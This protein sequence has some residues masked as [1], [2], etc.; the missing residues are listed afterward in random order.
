M[1]EEE[2]FT[3]PAVRTLLQR[4]VCVRLDVDRRPPEAVRYGV[5]SI[6]RLLVLPAGSD[7]PVMD[8]QGFLDAKQLA[9]ELRR[10]LGLKLEQA[11]PV[12]NAELTLV[13]RALR[14]R[15]F[16][17]LKA[18]N[19]RTAQAGL[20]QLVARLGVFQ[21]AQLAPTAALIRSAGDD[22]IPALIQGMGHRHL[23]VRVAS[24]RTLQGVLSDRRLAGVPTFDAWAPT[25]TRQLQLQRWVHWW[26]TRRS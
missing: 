7:Q 26:K 9:E 12:E 20:G 15:Q 25:A 23:A 5:N 4:V 18:S 3:D 6:P 21:E 13:R 17:A 22:A 24:Y 16:A 2:T 14:N 10:V 11:A 1:M 8:V 19:P